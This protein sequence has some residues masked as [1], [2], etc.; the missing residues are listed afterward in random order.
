MEPSKL[1]VIGIDGFDPILISEWERE[2]PNLQSIK[3]QGL[4]L[5][6]RSVFPPDSIPA[7]ATILALSE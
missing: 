7:W 1:V 5:P 4:S 2:L 3:D 6:L